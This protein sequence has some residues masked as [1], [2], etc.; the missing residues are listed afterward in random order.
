MAPAPPRQPKNGKR[1]RRDSQLDEAL[2]DTFPASDPPAMLAP[3]EPPEDD[4][5]D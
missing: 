2:A 3:H 4:D 5:E 1:K